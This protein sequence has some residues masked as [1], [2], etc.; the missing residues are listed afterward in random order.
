MYNFFSTL[1]NNNIVLNNKI[2]L[3]KT[4][5]IIQILNLLIN[6]GLIRGYEEKKKHIYVFSKF[7]KN[8]SIITQIKIISKPSKQVYIKNKDLYKLNKKLFFISTVKGIITVSKAKE[9]NL[10]GKLI[11]EVCL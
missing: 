11:C 7:F 9:E 5:K 10:G 2:K 8:K 1:N 3:K 4:K 6:E